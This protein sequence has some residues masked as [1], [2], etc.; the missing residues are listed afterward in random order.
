MDNKTLITFTYDNANDKFLVNNDEA[1]A[2]NT[3]LNA[4]RTYA[5]AIKQYCQSLCNTYQDLRMQVYVMANCYGARITF[6][7]NNANTNTRG[8]I[9]DT[10]IE[11]SISCKMPYYSSD[12]V[13]VGITQKYNG[14]KATIR[15]NTNSK[16]SKTWFKSDNNLGNQT[17]YTSLADSINVNKC[18]DDIRMIIDAKKHII[19]RNSNLNFKRIAQDA[20]AKLNLQLNSIDIPNWF[21]DAFAKHN[22]T[23]DMHSDIT[24][25]FKDKESI[26]E[27]RLFNCYCITVNANA[28]AVYDTD[29][30]YFASIKYDAAFDTNSSHAR[31]RAN[32]LNVDI[33]REMVNVR[34]NNIDNCTSKREQVIAKLECL[35]QCTK[36][37]H[38]NLDNM[39]ADFATM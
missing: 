32:H 7:I 23:P 5:D 13:R 4:L 37:V 16:L 29:T 12:N 2:V 10:L 34:C 19:E 24:T 14:S 26:Y 38:D 22:I 28:Y 25:T 39:F 1:H 3:S 18:V 6:D 17:C 21:A 20:E 27:V 9:Y 36:I 33:I 35:M 15:A 8:S 31:K 30:E 11:L